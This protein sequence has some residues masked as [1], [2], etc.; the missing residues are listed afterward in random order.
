MLNKKYIFLFQT[1]QK[2]HIPI[3][4]DKKINEKDE[5]FWVHL[6]TKSKNTFIKDYKSLAE[7]TI[8]DN[9]KLTVQ[10]S[11][12]TR[13]K[14]FIIFSKQNIKLFDISLVA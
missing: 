7:V 11:H 8:K 10:E 4:D 2:I 5:V 3:I 14:D 12:T 6:R 9:D 13:K 1:V